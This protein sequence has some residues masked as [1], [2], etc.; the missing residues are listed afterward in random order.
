M[1]LQVFPLKLQF[2]FFLI[3]TGEIKRNLTNLHCNFLVVFIGLSLK[4]LT[5]NVVV[6]SCH[7]RAHTRAK[8]LAVTHTCRANRDLPISRVLPLVPGDLGVMRKRGT[9]GAENLRQQERKQSVRALY[10]VSEYCTECQSTKESVRVLWRVSE[11]CRECQSTMESVRV[12]WRVGDCGE[13]LPW[14]E[15]RVPVRFGE[16]ERTPESVSSLWRVLAHSGEC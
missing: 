9:S 14:Y 5:F 4:Y 12:L 7:M 16:C 13:C 2:A 3:K 8:I 15:S 6:K 1:L 11:H 10:R